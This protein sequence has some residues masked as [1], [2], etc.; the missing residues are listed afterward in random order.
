MS[1][2]FQVV[3]SHDGSAVFDMVRSNGGTKAFSAEDLQQTW[4]KAI[5]DQ[6]LAGNGAKLASMSPVWINNINI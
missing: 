2:A 3:N 5:R 4:G 1:F 6:C